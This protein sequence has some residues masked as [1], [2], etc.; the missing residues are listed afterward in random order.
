LELEILYNARIMARQPEDKLARPVGL[1][2]LTAVAINGIVGAAIFVLP[3][4]V[5]KLLGPASPLAYLIAWFAVTLIGLCFAEL[6]SIYES[7]GGPYVYAKAAFGSFVAFEVAWFFLLA[8]LTAVAAISNGFTA[9][10]GQFWPQLAA[11]PGRVLVITLM[12]VVLAAVNFAGVRYA[13][14][15][16]NLLTIG[17][18]VP[19]LIFIAVGL[20]WLDR[21]SY[22]FTLPASGTALRSA[23]LVLIFALGGFEYASVPSEE[24]THPRRDTPISMMAA[25]TICACLYILIQMIALSTLPGLADSS[26]PLAE[27][28]VRFLGPAGATLLAAGAILSTGG[29]NSAI[30]LVGPRLLYAMARD[31]QLPRVLARLHPRFGTPHISIVCFAL[32]AWAAATYSNF[33]QLAALSAIARLPYFMTTSLAIPVLRHKQPQLAAQRKF[34]IAGGALIPLLAAAVCIWLL[35]GSSRSQA[36]LG[37]GALAS[38]ALIYLSSRLFAQ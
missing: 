24:V 16:I 12:I 37:L 17:K 36:L 34:R 7:S 19:L 29:T 20:F 27:A 23:S 38:G 15:A 32:L 22:S 8:R 14:W 30:M 35:T 6:G 4:T 1:F 9:Y 3:A 25:I 18:L 11:G 28:A 10:L 5:A 2:S 21:G 26:R 33:A 13:A 31:G